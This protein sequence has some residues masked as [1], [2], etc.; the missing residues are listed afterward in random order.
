MKRFL[1]AIMIPGVMVGSIAVAGAQASAKGR[2][3]EASYYGGQFYW[4]HLSEG[5]PDPFRRRELRRCSESGLMGC[6]T[7]ETEAS[8]GSLSAKVIDALG[9]QV[10]VLVVA[11]PA[12]STDLETR[13]IYGSF[14]GET[15][16]AISFDPG[17]KLEFWIGSE[18]WPWWWI[19]PDLDCNPGPATTGTISITLS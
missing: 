15:T 11:A 3:V 16:Q 13:K 5:Y 17:T 10:S 7:V 1:I 2:T 12:S 9:Q 18:W 14:C 19:V 4:P 8:E 6:V